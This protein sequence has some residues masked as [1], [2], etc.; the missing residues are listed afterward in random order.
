M[1]QIPVCFVSCALLLC[2]IFL[3]FFIRPSYL[4]IFLLFTIY[5]CCLLYILFQHLQFCCTCTITNKGLFYS[6]L[7]YSML[8]YCEVDM[9]RNCNNLVKTMYR[10]R[11]GSLSADSIVHNSHQC[12]GVTTIAELQTSFGIDIMARPS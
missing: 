1:Y 3:L 6:I 9:F 4:F 8:C 11:V 12:Y 5:S 10:Y 2:F 7:L